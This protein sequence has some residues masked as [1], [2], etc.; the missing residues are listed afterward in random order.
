MCVLCRP[1][2]PAT[3][4]EPAGIL[5]TLD[6]T[7]ATLVGVYQVYQVEMGKKGTIGVGQSASEWS[8]RLYQ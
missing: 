7:L 3:C 6:A 2:S 5:V 4:G 8:E 1:S